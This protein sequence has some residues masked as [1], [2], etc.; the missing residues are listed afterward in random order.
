[1]ETVKRAKKVRVLTKM[2]KIAA[3]TAQLVRAETSMLLEVWKKKTSRYF[4]NLILY[5]IYEEAVSA[6]GVA[7]MQLRS[8][9]TKMTQGEDIKMLV[10]CLELWH[11]NMKRTIEMGID[12]KIAEWRL[13]TDQHI[14]SST[15]EMAICENILTQAHH[16][17]VI[18][19]T[20][21][22]LRYKSSLKNM[23]VVE[24]ERVL[25]EARASSPPDPAQRLV[26]NKMD[27][28]DIPHTNKDNKVI[29]MT[30]SVRGKAISAD[31]PQNS[32]AVWGAAWTS[33]KTYLLQQAFG[34][35]DEGIRSTRVVQGVVMGHA[36]RCKQAVIENAATVVQGSISGH[37]RRQ[38]ILD[39]DNA[40][41]QLQASMNGHRA[42]LD[43]HK[44]AVAQNDS[45][46]YVQAGIK[47]HEIRQQNAV[48]ENAKTVIQGGI[49]GHASRQ[50]HLSMDAAATQVQAGLNGRQARVMQHD[51]QDAIDRIQACCQGQVARTAAYDLRRQQYEYED[52]AASQLQGATLG[53]Q[54]RNSTRKEA[55]Q[56]RVLQAGIVGHVVRQEQATRDVAASHVQAAMMGADAREV[57]CELHQRMVKKDSQTI[58]AGVTGW[59]TR[60]HHRQLNQ[61][62]AEIRGALTAK[63]AGQ[64]ARQYCKELSTSQ[65]TSAMRLQATVVG[66]EARQKI[67][68][69]AT[70]IDSSVRYILAGI[71]GCESRRATATTTMN[72]SASVIQ[73]S[74]IG[75]SMRKQVTCINHEIDVIKLRA[76][77]VDT[78][79]Q[80]LSAGIQGMQARKE[81][82]K[83]WYEALSTRVEV[84]KVLQGAIRGTQSRLDIAVMAIK[85]EEGLETP[86]SGMSEA[87]VARW[88]EARDNAIALEIAVCRCRQR[89][90][91]RACGPRGA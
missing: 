9:Y 79:G 20:D 72:K 21:K 57:A 81:A 83:W 3:I 37:A 56:A 53:F 16:D 48:I 74:L 2:L 52:E 13:L 24:R 89:A 58:Q 42:R 41:I 30:A 55:K 4:R 18:K 66:H 91:L 1:M 31:A 17:K 7:I 54:V 23:E 47:G 5:Q 25:E 87:A 75:H 35:E 44:V 22:I 86:P 19:K 49:S 34:I 46:A 14:A 85:A 60:N 27:E 8:A 50:R 40:A 65:E 82:K 90:S 6:R 11:R 26:K 69:K 77:V 32:Q 67:V 61:A 28:R 76:E 59:V 63:R 36:V 73:A 39:M 71:T 38:H 12:T 84:T 15:S 70:D 80:I 88:T 68:T 45:C 51:A 43:V 10:I 29:E 33:V 78:A 64:Q 62:A